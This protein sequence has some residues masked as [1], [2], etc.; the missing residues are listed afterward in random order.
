MK[1]N[2]IGKSFKLVTNFLNNFHG[3]DHCE[4]NCKKTN[5]YNSSRNSI[6]FRGTNPVGRRSNKW[7]NGEGNNIVCYK[8]K[9]V[10]H[11]A[12]NCREPINHPKLSS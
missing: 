4:K 1:M 11:I 3:F 2:C 5:F 8:C 7:S 10:G 12:R 9:N 6:M